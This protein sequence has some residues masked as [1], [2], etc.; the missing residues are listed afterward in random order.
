MN[1]QAGPT[2]TPDLAIHHHGQTP[3]GVRMAGSAS[4]GQGLPRNIRRAGRA[5]DWPGREFGIRKP[6]PAE[7][8]LSWCEV[9]HFLNKG[10]YL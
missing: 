1:G 5:Y 7:T 4:A 6:Y 10:A 9:N 3:Q 8:A 2:Q